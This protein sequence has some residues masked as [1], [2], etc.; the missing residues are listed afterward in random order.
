MQFAVARTPALRKPDKI[1]STF[2]ND[3]GRSQRAN[4]IRDGNHPYNVA[5]HPADQGLHDGA[6]LARPAGLVENAI[7]Q[8][9]PKEGWVE[10]A[11]VTGCDNK[12]A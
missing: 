7:W 6:L 11:R 3:D 2:Q 4:G 9:G 10:W 1:S 8:G 5:R 12:R